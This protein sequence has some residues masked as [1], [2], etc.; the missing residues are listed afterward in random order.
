[1]NFNA[2]FFGQMLAFAVFI[3]FCMKFIWPLLLRML[4]EREKR[5]AD[6]LAAAEEGQNK[7]M[8]A[9]R[10]LREHIDE[11]KQ[12]AAEIINQAQR[13]GDEIIE[14]AKQAAKDEGDRQLERARVEIEQEREQVR[15]GLKQQ[16][17][18]L[19]VAGARQILQREVK[20]QD[21]ESLLG[22]LR[23]RI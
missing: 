7:L 16:L 18:A 22:R 2:T 11:G 6:G 15:E 17:A 9:D 8:E 3:G 4:E 19:A 12:R 1:M 10:V 23:E 5:I 14:E 13:R 20:Q 21:H